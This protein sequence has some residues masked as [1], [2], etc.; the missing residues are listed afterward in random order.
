MVWGFNEAVANGL[1]MA[2]RRQPGAGRR[3]PGGAPGWRAHLGLLGAA[4]AVAAAPW[5]AGLGSGPLV[6][7]LPAL[8]RWPAVVLAAALSQA[9]LWAEVFLI[10]GLILDALGGRPAP[11]DPAGHLLAG[12]RKGLVFGGVFMGLLFGIGLLVQSPAAARVVT[13][14]LPIAA[15]LLG[16]AAFPLAKTLMETFDGTQGFFR[17]L[18]G[19]YR[20]PAFFLRGAVV[21][22]GAGYAF[23]QAMSLQATPQRAAFGAAVGLAAYA[24]MSLLR[25][26]LRQ[27]LRRGKVQTWRVYLVQAVLGGLIGAGLGFY[28]DAAQAPVVLDKLQQY[29]RLGQAPQAYG[30]YLLLSK[31]GYLQLGAVT[32][33]V[34]LLFNESLIGVL[35]WAVPAWLFAVNATFMSAAFR[36]DKAPIA[37]LFTGQGLRGLGRNTVQVLRW[38]LWMAPIIF[39]FLRPMADPTWYNQDGAVRTLLAAFHF[40]TSSPQAFHAWSLGV[41]APILACNA[42]RILVWLDHM[43]LRVAT[44][45]NLSFLGMDRLDRRLARFLGPA[46][47][48]QCI[49]E[50]IKRFA[51]W[52]P[53]LIPF[54]LP[55]GADWDRV[56]SQRGV[57]PGRR[58]QRPGRA[59]RAAARHADPPGL[60]RR[61]RRHGP[62]RRLPPPQGAPRVAAAGRVEAGQFPLRDGPQGE[63]RDVQ[64]RP[65]AGLRRQPPLLRPARS[66]RQGL[67]PG[68]PGLRGRRSGPRLAPARPFPAAAAR[69]GRVEE[70]DGS[71]Q[72][73]TTMNGIEAAVEV[74]LAGDD[75]AELWTIRVENL[76]DRQRRLKVAPYLE[77]V[78]NRPESD[79][80][81][82]QYNRLY[83]EMEYVGG[84]H[85]VLAWH[86][87]SKAMGF[88]AADAEPEGFLTS[89]IDFIGRAQSIASPRVLSTLAFAAAADTGAHPTFDP[90]GSLL[91]GAD[92]GPGGSARIRILIGSTG[93]KREAIGLIARH[94]AVPGANAV[95]AGR[96]SR[97]SAGAR[98]AIRSGMARSCP[99]RRSPTRS[100]AG[101]GGSCWSARP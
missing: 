68:R 49:P 87:Q 20:H 88:L 69:A 32:G 44:L 77:W 48:A 28:F 22:L 14:H 57:A 12:L 73:T 61:R 63:R 10:T 40:L 64:P 27:L 11:A 36:K 75:P 2:A 34:R 84:L 70:R 65:R 1:A 43:G 93:S 13:G 53:L 42:V 56:W 7:S 62:V 51:T 21:G 50:G 67:V 18:S 94:L 72:I 24:G 30:S 81:H 46:A 83:P 96:R 15:A 31:W 29:L 4:A 92:L 86:K 85:A 45:V 59:V 33:G 74:R 71:L 60:R 58:R 91:V 99:E 98:A 78:L 52:A 26:G 55:R 16:A 37:A 23:S 100:T 6:S 17:R 101:T 79:R 3:P 54:Y 8:G 19:C 97:P 9:A 47:T 66:G 80:G 39:T 35:S 76:T 82:T 25:D 89:R 95:P 41:F 5:I 90:I 38:G